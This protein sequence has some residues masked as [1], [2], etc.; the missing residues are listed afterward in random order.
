MSN[1]KA[2]DKPQKHIS[3]IAA[4]L[5]PFWETY[6]NHHDIIDAKFGAKLGYMGKE[7]GEPRELCVRFFPNEIDSGKDFYL[8]LFDWDQN[9]YHEG[10]RVLYRHKWD[11]AWRETGK[12]ADVIVA[13][14]STPTFAIR[15]SDLEEVNRSPIT[16]AFPVI[17]K[18]N[19][20]N[21]DIGL[22]TALEEE[23]SEM[24]IEQEDDHYTKMTI[25]DIYCI[26]NE[27]PLSNKKWLNN[28]I[29]KGTEWKMKK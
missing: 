21:D 18:K 13:S 5:K 29:K 2:E 12:Y 17:E 11:P 24:F 26:M 4:E 25:R 6:F 8:E 9:L 22:F 15:V 1:F 23:H 20:K 10:E 3:Q 7:F 28:L 19:S 14:L 27:V 16:A